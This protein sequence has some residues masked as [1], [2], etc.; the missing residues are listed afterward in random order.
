MAGLVN[1]S[2]ELEAAVERASRSVVAV[3]GRARLGS[4]GIHWRPG[5]VVT[6]DHTVQVDD[7]VKLTAPGGRKIQ[8]VVAGRDPG[9]DLAIL[10]ADLS[11][12][13]VADLGEGVEVRVG[14]LV[15]AVGAGPRA[16]WGIVSALGGEGRLRGAGTPMLNLDL[17]LYPGFSGGPLVDVQGRVVGVNTSSGSRH[18]QLAVPV[19]AVSR[20]VADLERRGRI[21]RAWLG[22]GTQPVRLPDAARDRLGVSQRSAVIVVEVQPGSPAATAGL[23]IG[24]VIVALGGMPVTAPEDLFAVL[25][26]ERVGQT[27]T[28]SLLRAGESREISVTVGERPSRS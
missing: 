4:T 27:V 8:A 22:V 16:S 12:V 11:D 1:L 21:P 14:H 6:A 3:H 20:A 18:L 24:D 23:A 17:T 2:D 5:L 15:L 28:A 7:D 26:P 19:A 9:L 25:R 13:P 10:R